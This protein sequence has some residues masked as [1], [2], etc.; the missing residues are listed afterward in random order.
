[1]KYNNLQYNTMGRWVAGTIVSL[2][3]RGMFQVLF[4]FHNFLQKSLWSEFTTYF[5]SHLG[6]IPKSSQSHHKSFQS[7]FNIIPKWFNFN[8]AKWILGSEL[9]IPNIFWTNLTNSG[10]GGTCV[11]HQWSVPCC[12]DENFLETDLV[13]WLKH[14]SW[15]IIN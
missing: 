8:D 13:F 14:D 1:M 5:Q 11:T 4:F 2:T 7:H 12:F 15:L 3:K 10:H 9:K 6:V